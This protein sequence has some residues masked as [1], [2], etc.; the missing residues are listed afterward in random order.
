M[1]RMDTNE[2]YNLKIKII[3]NK[4]KIRLNNWRIYELLSSLKF[5]KFLTK[6][7]VK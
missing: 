3:I 7:N 6:F 5:L 1:I 4:T 2:I